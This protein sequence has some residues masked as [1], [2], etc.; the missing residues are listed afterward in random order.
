MNKRLLKK[1]AE[2]V[3]KVGVNVQKGQGVVL[4]CSIDQGKFAALLTE[5]AYKAGAK[6]VEIQ[7]QYQETD[8]LDQNYQTLEQL[9]QVTP[10]ELAKEEYMLA[11]L[12]ALIYVLS[13]D[14]D[15]LNGVD[16]EKLQ[17]SFAAR[18]QAVKKYRDAREN[19]YQ[20]TIVAAPS[21]QWAKK[22]FPEDRAPVAVKKL[23]DAILSTVHL[24]PQNDPIQA[25]AE[26]N[27][28]FQAKTSWLTDY[29]FDY[30]HYTS[31]RGT[32]FKAWLIDG[33]QWL[34]GSEA[35]LDGVVFNPNMP[36]EEVFTTPLKGKAEGIL[37][38]TK[39]LS[40]QGQLIED[41]SLTFKDGKAVDCT[42]AKGEKLLREML[43][44]DEGAAYIGELA[45]V[46]VTS[47]IAQ[48][49]LLFYETLFDENASCHVA[50]GRGFSMALP[51]YQSMSWSEVVAGGINDSLIHVDFMIGDPTLNVTGHTRDGK[52]VPIFAQG[53]WAF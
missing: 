35:T 52:S 38:A 13:D 41:F 27:A 5:A 9:S 51:D 4:R 8:K 50:L 45:L 29:N 3:V 11:E 42:A 10:W 28:N 26:H 53:N 15:G 18:K 47:P 37:Y 32:D 14:P 31:D 12:P 17:R 43:A 19:K 46:P 25:W 49:G 39:P 36:T 20:W 1:Y 40:Y 23:G 7:W 44:T 16:Q 21:T 22:V 34:G 2:L 6:W 30:L 24:T 33:G 48:S